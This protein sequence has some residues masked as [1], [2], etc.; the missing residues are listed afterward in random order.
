MNRLKEYCIPFLQLVLVLNL[1]SVF[2]FNT[3]SQDVVNGMS[4]T[5][6]EL[7]D[8]NGNPAGSFRMNLD[9]TWSQDSTTEKNLF[10]YQES[11]RDEWSVYLS[12]PSRDLIVSLD[13]WKKEVYF[14]NDV[15]FLVISASNEAVIVNGPGVTPEE[16]VVEEPINEEEIIGA[17][18]R[19]FLHKLDVTDAG[20]DGE[21]GELYGSIRVDGQLVWEIP[22]NEALTLEDGSTLVFNHTGLQQDDYYI[23]KVC[24]FNSGQDCSFTITGT[25]MDDDPDEVAQLN[26]QDLLNTVRIH[27]HLNR[28]ADD[29]VS[30][31]HTTLWPQSMNGPE[32][33]A[34][35]G[36]QTQTLQG[37]SYNG[38]NTNQG[39]ST[40][41]FAVE[42]ACHI[43]HEASHVV[44]QKKAR[45]QP[46]IA[47]TRA[48][49]VPEIAAAPRAG[50]NQCTNK[51]LRVTDK[52]GNGNTV[53]GAIVWYFDTIIYRGD[54]DISNALNRI[55]NHID[56]EYYKKIHS[57]D[58]NVFHNYRCRL[59][60]KHDGYYV[61]FVIPTQGKNGPGAQRLVIGDGDEVYYTGDHYTTFIRVY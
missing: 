57:H 22:E 20:D 33:F 23:E 51:K 21:A 55:Q 60:G 8:L 26:R 54:I 58:R 47:E 50:K 45:C 11:N 49:G 53:K 42:K 15:K 10:S 32:A 35:V 59:P 40:A 4:V 61:E 27:G 5:K 29:V 2:S 38:G 12:D 56:D 16:P 37:V 14:G 18:Y 48:A 44:Q 3:L 9:G 19:L 13:L 43:T 30:N 1:I 36:P 52:R 46:A 39:A 6:V 7:N 25:I 31:I 24:L 17:V 34:Y 28:G 41:W